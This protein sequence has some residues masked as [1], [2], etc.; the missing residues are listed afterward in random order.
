[1]SETPPSLE[2]LWKYRSRDRGVSA[3]LP[4]L[5]HGYG[6]D[7]ATTTVHYTV[8]GESPGIIKSMGERIPLIQQEA[9]ALTGR[10]IEFLTRV[11]RSELAAGHGVLDVRL[12]M[13]PNHRLAP[14]DR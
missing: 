12:L 7:H 4:L 5:T 1:M 6:P 2:L 10:T 13:S 8:V 3:P 9:E 14:L 11:A